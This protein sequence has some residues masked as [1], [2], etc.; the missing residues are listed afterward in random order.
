MI[1]VAF[2]ETKLGSISSC[3]L[4][5]QTI[6]VDWKI[7]FLHLMTTGFRMDGIFEYNENM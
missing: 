6:P 1:P 5:A 2:Q 7:Q 3:V 4:V